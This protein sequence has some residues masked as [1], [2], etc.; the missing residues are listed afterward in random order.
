MERTCKKTGQ[1]WPYVGI[2]ISFWMA[3][4][5]ILPYLGLFY[6]S[7]GYEE[8]MIGILSGLFQFMVVLSAIM[9]GAIE[10]KTGR[11]GPMI[12]GLTVG[13]CGAAALLYRSNC[14]FL[15]LLFVIL[16]SFCY[17]PVNGI[18]D[19]VLM[20]KLK[21]CPEQYAKCR[22]GG[23]VGAG[24]GIIAAAIL[25]REDNFFPIFCG[26][27]A[28]LLPCVVCALF[29]QRE[30]RK[31]NVVPKLSD[32]GEILKNKRSLSIYLAL[33]AWGF[34]ESGTGTFQAILFK[35]AGLPVTLTSFFVVLAM[36]GEFIAFQMVPRISFRLPF[37]R[38]LVLSFIL[39]FFRIFSMALVQWLPTWMVAFFQLTGGGSFAIIH[40]MMT[41][42]VDRVYPPKLLYMAHSLKRVA[43][44]GIGN[45]LGLVLLGQMFQR[46]V[47][48]Q[49]YVIIS[50]V[51]LLMAFIF[52]KSGK[53][54]IFKQ[55]QQ[56]NMG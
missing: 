2:F 40:T 26:F 38:L 25:V 30:E 16:L 10:D 37:G 5:T 12:I 3:S 1:V 32:Y 50:F 20:E 41:M 11:P 42:E 8:G 47:G 51:S 35:N 13:M 39:Q 34:S 14:Y 55:S 28:F 23:T 54:S 9:V 48:E 53:K 19:K 36:A 27:C 7:K 24:L 17:A 29:F 52:L 6:E 49:A 56:K 44:N 45:M 33:A 31:Q 4:N 22:S 46:E 43:S 15:T 18:T 21:A